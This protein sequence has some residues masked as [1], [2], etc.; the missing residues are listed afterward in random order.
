MT[1]LKSLSPFKV[2]RLLLLLIPFRLR[3]AKSFALKT[4]FVNISVYPLKNLLNSSKPVSSTSSGILGATGSKVAA[5]F[6]VVCFGVYDYSLN[7]ALP[8][9]SKHQGD[10]VSG[11]I[12]FFCYFVSYFETFLL[13]WFYFVYLICNLQRVI[14][15]INKLSFYNYKFHCWLSKSDLS[16]WK[17]YLLM[18]YLI[19]NVTTFISL[20]AM[21]TCFGNI[22]VINKSTILDSSKKV[23][24]KSYFDCTRF[25]VFAQPSSVQLANYWC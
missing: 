25:L 10:D 1:I 3:L 11:M 21:L 4:F 23:T 14:F 6:F 15:F 24:F 20:Q 7:P 5:K 13:V 12:R 18:L 17:Y 9:S 2:I 8:V 22:L 19:F 16:L